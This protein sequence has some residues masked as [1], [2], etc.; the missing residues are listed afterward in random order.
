M[1]AL[2][3]T[4]SRN[5][6]RTPKVKDKARR[7]AVSS[8]V[9]SKKEGPSPLWNGGEAITSTPVAF[10]GC[11]GACGPSRRNAPT[12]TVNGTTTATSPQTALV[13]RTAQPIYSKKSRCFCQLSGIFSA[14][15]L[16][17]AK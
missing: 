10:V 9:Q 4:H 14:K 17:T 3:R 1:P 5:A 16:S 13:C 7:K 11:R 12:A 8:G 2:P 6:G 15:F